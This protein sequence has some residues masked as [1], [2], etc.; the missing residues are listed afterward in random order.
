MHLRNKRSLAGPRPP[1]DA[2]RLKPKPDPHAAALEQTGCV[3]VP[4]A[5]EGTAAFVDAVNAGLKQWFLANLRD[6]RHFSG[7]SV[8][9]GDAK[10]QRRLFDAGWR[11]E[12]LGP[13][14]SKAVR[15]AL[16]GNA[17]TN[18]GFGA[19]KSLCLNGFGI[20][21]HLHAGFAIETTRFS[22]KQQYKHR[23]KHTYTT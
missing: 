19:A 20:P 12:H 22:T 23:Y 2:K 21:S 5:V 16:N 3:G 14:A 18:Q 10:T 9:L 4:L 7:S 15:V 11:S 13:E 17:G 1:P 6:S 8:D